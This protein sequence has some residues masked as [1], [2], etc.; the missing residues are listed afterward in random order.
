MA[1]NTEDKR[2]Y[3]TLIKTFVDG[4]SDR[5]NGNGSNGHSNGNGNGATATI[6]RE[7]EATPQQLDDRQLAD[8]A[9]LEPDDDDLLVSPS[10]QIDDDDEDDEDISRSPLARIALVGGIIGAVVLFALFVVA[11]FGGGTPEVAE[12]PETQPEETE[13]SFDES[14]RYKSQLALIDQQKNRVPQE[15]DPANVSTPPTEEEK[16]EK[17]EESEEPE[18]QTP[19]A[20]TP[21]PAPAPTPAP[22]PAPAPAPVPERPAPR[23][24][25]APAP[26]QY[27]PAPAPAPAI[28]P[29]DP[30]ERWKQLA[31]A[32]TTKTDG[33][34]LPANATDDA[35]ETETMPNMRVRRS[36][37]RTN[38]PTGIGDF[39]ADTLGDD[40]YDMTPN[41]DEGHRE[42][43]LQSR[44]GDGVLIASTSLK[45]LSVGEQGI[46]QRRPVRSDETETTDEIDET[47]TRSRHEVPLGSIAEAELIVPIVATPDGETLG[48][49]AIELTEPL[50]S[51][52][53]EIALP[54]GSI[55]MTEVVGVDRGSLAI[56]LTVVAVVF[57]DVNG[58]LQQ[59]TLEPGVLL[60]RGDGD[61]ALIA[62]R[63][64]D[65]DPFFRDL[66]AGVLA[67]AGRVGEILN[68]PDVA[69]SVSTGGGSSSSST[70]VVQGDP[71]L[72]GAA[73]DGLFNETSDRLIDRIE[74]EERPEP[75]LVVEADTDVV[76]FTNGFL[77]VIR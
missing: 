22:A 33:S 60:I 69:T 17:P 52:D 2:D 39:P 19:S 70:T 71:D 75:V 29:V 63:E 62:D 74:N 47:A 51:T 6:E 41:E 28:E 54:E 10:H 77:S 45:N 15:S 35:G 26:Q 7:T 1:Q 4:D 49:F 11:L 50:L 66:A 32:G 44:S 27:R 16:E 9:D 43:G 73:L 55:L 46:I 30:I 40:P 53:E 31:G 36:G 8:L 57:R 24:A 58:V 64:G 18:N 61:E 23:P 13:E 38:T 68:Q 3:S 14:D 72:V 42:L 5:Q 20:P 56:Q 67:G 76:V 25:P 65:G 37:D 48:R 59:E 12:E 21:A 34:V